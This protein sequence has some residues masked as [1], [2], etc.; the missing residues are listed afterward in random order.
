MRTVR[1]ILGRYRHT[2]RKLTGDRLLLVVALD[3]V[4]PVNA[5]VGVGHLH[6]HDLGPEGENDERLSSRA[7]GY[8]SYDIVQI[9]TE[10]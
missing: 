9:S 1:R 2:W 8:A 4:D 7:C 6:G 3:V 10:N 5:D